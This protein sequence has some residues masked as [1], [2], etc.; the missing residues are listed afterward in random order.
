[1]KTIL[2]TLFILI[3]FSSCDDNTNA[4]TID[5]FLGTWELKNVII[6]GDAIS[7]P[8]SKIT[9]VFSEKAKNLVF[10]GQ[11]TCNFYGG[12]VIKVTSRKDIS[13]SAMYS[14]EMACSPDLLNMYENDYYKWLTQTNQYSIEDNK[15]VLSFERTNLNFEKVN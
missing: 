14:T 6:E 4:D 10:S 1:M 9:I 8:P 7:T 11:S 5:P 12:D 13:L 3:I 2:Y 15:L